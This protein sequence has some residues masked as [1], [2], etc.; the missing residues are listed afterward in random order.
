MLVG[1]VDGV[2]PVVELSLNCPIVEEIVISND[3]L[4]ATLDSLNVSFS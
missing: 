2:V 4:Y 3:L 1:D